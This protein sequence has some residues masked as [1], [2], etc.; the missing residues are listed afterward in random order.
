MCSLTGWRMRQPEHHQLK[1][2][3]APHE[4]TLVGP[5]T[6]SPRQQIMR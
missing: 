6:A 4:W 5:G 3:H 2:K 1:Y